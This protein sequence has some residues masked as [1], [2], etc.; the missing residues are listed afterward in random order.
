MGLPIYQSSDHSP[1]NNGQGNKG[2]KFER[3]FNGYNLQSIDIEKEKDKDKA[4]KDKAKKDFLAEFK[5][6]C[7]D[8][9]LL[10][11]QIQR[12]IVLNQVSNGQAQAYE[13]TGHFVTGMGNSHPVENGFSWHY[14]LGV[15]YIGG[16]QVKGVLRS[17]IEQYYVAEDRNEILKT[18]FGSA[19]KSDV[20]TQAG[21]LIFFDALPTKRPLLTVDI[22]TLHMG[23]WYSDGNKINDAFKDTEQL[24]ADWH[25]PNPIPFLA[26]KDAT[27]LFNI[28]K[29]PHSDIDL[30]DV[31]ECLTEALNYCGMGA[32]TQTGYGFME[33]RPK[34][35]DDLYAEIQ[36]KEAQAQELAFLEQEKS[37]ASPLKV[38]LLEE[39]K[40]NNW[41]EI[42]DA[43]KIN[44][45]DALRTK[46]LE[47][48]ENNSEDKDCI[49]LFIDIFK[50][51]YA[52]QWEKPNGKKV[53]PNHRQWVE[54]LK[55]LMDK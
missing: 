24:P 2:L 11:Q 7:G 41:R 12:Q 20:D 49:A 47:L 18:W 27:F 50:I 10:K 14:T 39:I 53:K 40:A 54:S 33:A 4:K 23:K 38:E 21:E 42:G 8:D 44:F 48:L 16:S 1:F 5:G 9:N 19:D 43:A 29:R 36:E 22:M 17:F 3:F 28:A 26:V 37:H 45:T 35:V 51:H 31:F 34:I 13:L 15:P 52:K 25:D 30:N 46:W 55:A 32:K 6:Y